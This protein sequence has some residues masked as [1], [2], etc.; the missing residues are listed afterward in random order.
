MNRAQSTLTA[1]IA[2]AGIAGGLAAEPLPWSLAPV[3]RPAVPKVKDAAWLKD[4]VDV[5]VLARLEAAGIA[6]NPDANRATWLRRASFDLTGLPPRRSRRSC[7]IPARTIWRLPKCSTGYSPLRVSANAGDGT[8]WTW[9]ITRTRWAAL[10]T[11]RFFT[12]GG[13]AIGS[14]TRSMRTSPTT[15]LWENRSL[16]TCC[17]RARRRSGV[18]ISRARVSLRSV[19]WSCR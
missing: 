4:G 5:F 3:R 9:C 11:R 16:A 2:F 6:P 19:R 14:S 8:G 15:S 1:C 13:I 10:G 7:A 18:R 17:R 12:R